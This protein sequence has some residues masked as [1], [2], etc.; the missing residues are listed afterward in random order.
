[1]DKLL[2]TVIVGLFWLMFWIG[3]VSSFTLVDGLTFEGFLFAI[4]QIGTLV[5]YVA[6]PILLSLLLVRFWDRK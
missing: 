6:V 4:G 5:F 3:T 1:M 2:K